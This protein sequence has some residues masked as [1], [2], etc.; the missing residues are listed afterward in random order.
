MKRFSYTIAVC[1]LCFLATACV[2]PQIERKNF[3]KA[4]IN[5]EAEKQRLAF[6]KRIH[7]EEARLY[8]LSAP[9]LAKNQDI[10]NEL[11]DKKA[12]AM[13]FQTIRLNKFPTEY[14]RAAKEVY[15]LTKD[16]LV[17]RH[18]FDGFDA[19]KQGLR[20]GDEILAIAGIDVPNQPS[21]WEAFDKKLKERMNEI[22]IQAQEKVAIVIRRGDTTAVRR[23]TPYFTCNYSINYYVKDSKNAY[24]D[25]KKIAIYRG[26]LESLEDEVL[27]MVIAHELAH[28]VMG[29]VEATMK[30]IR[31]GQFLGTIM[32]VFSLTQGIET[33]GYWSDKTP[34]YI[35][36][37]YSQDFEVEADYVGLYLYARSGY[38]LDRA[39]D[40]W[41][42]MAVATN[43]ED[44]VPDPKSTHPSTA[45]RF[46]QMEAAIEEIREKQ[47]NGEPLKPELG[48]ISEIIEDISEEF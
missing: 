44:L 20:K 42:Q 35:D 12:F 27:A 6:L 30:N 16:N 1:I 36:L 46:L 45:E 38:S 3:T 24:A 5:A 48:D 8:N 26:L 19:Q 37:H 4:Q 28:N 2:G 18:V 23:I 33:G 40:T 22:D 25:G 13:G 29:H 47:K 43:L 11:A 41:R 32:D 21:D 34:Q 10:C 7:E 9:I 39:V 15:S 14:R 17:V 31:L